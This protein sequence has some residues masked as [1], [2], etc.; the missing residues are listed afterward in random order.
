MNH[1]KNISQQEI[2]ND[3]TITG[4]YIIKVNN[5]Y[6]LYKKTIEMQNNGWIRNNPIPKVQNIKLAKYFEVE[7]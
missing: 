7:L 1:E 3:N 2:L 5:S 6:N 4:L